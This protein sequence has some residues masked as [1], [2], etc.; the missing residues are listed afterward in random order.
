MVSQKTE[1]RL[2][3]CY[4]YKGKRTGRKL[5]STT[6]SSSSSQPLVVIVSEI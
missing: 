6:S 5:L 3:N 1:Q 2:L 4:A